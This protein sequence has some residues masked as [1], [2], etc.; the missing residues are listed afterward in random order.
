[1]AGDR[2]SALASDAPAWQGRAAETYRSLMANNVDALGG[3]GVLAATM[4]SA[5]QAAGNLV[6]FTRDIVRAAPP[7]TS[8]P[9]TEDLIT[10]KTG[11]PGGSPDGHP[12]RI[13][14]D[15]DEPT[16]RSI[17]LENSAAVT[18][19]DQGWWDSAWTRRPSGSGRWP[20]C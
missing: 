6:Q 7:D 16:R 5:T 3:L 9:P 14:R 17:E 13:E 1:M 19:A 11:T 15:D 10:H 12:T 4:A 8:S 18:L 2:R 20:T